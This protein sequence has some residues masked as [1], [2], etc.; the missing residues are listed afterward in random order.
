MGWIVKEVLLNN[1]VF[2]KEVWIYTLQSYNKRESTTKGILCI[3]GF[4]SFDHLRICTVWLW[5]YFILFFSLLIFLIIF[6]A[7]EHVAVQKIA[8]CISCP[9][10]LER[11]FWVVVVLL[12]HVSF[13]G[14][15]PFSP[16]EAFLCRNN[17]QKQHWLLAIEDIEQLYPT[18]PQGAWPF[19]FIKFACSVQHSLK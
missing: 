18:V 4:H 10:W 7:V 2:F 16:K 1:K 5:N 14:S 13:V 17:M 12:Q 15:I 3:K 6:I 8:Y 9:L 11:V 19:K